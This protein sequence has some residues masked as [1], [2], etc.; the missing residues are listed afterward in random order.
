M[1]RPTWTPRDREIVE[2][3]AAKV[4]AL[5]LAQVARG[6]WEPSQ[7]REEHARNRLRLL[8]RAGLLDAYRVN[9]HPPLELRGP[10][11][12]WKPGEP[13][14]DA[15]AAATQL[16]ARWTEAARPTSVYTASP[17]AANLFGCS[18][19]ELPELTH[20]DHDL[21]LGE[22]FV[23]YLR[24]EPDAARRRWVGEAARPKAGYRV[25]DPDAFLVDDAGNTLRVIESGGKYDAGR[26]AEFHEHCAEHG[27]PYELW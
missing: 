6:W 10:V 23:A 22:V 25:K 19:G 7:R 16:Q 8:G 27:L 1:S 9:V 14:P 11:I 17:L 12:R 2:T 3:L 20:R 13:D 24:S 18:G 4:R 15:E 21:L 26:V 5:S